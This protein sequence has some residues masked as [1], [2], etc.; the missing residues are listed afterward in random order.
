V[1]KKSGAGARERKRK[2][3]TPDPQSSALSSVVIYM[4][5]IGEVILSYLV[6]RAEAAVAGREAKIT[7]RVP[8]RRL[9]Q[10]LLGRFLLAA[11]GRS[12]LL[13]TATKQTTRLSSVSLY[14]RSD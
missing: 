10:L 11:I 14:M 4:P 13:Q 7:A 12:D 6:Q 5:Y 1:R 8:S 9:L 3:V 2:T